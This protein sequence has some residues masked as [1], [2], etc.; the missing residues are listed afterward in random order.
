MSFILLRYDFVL[1]TR[2]YF[3]YPILLTNDLHRYC[4]VP[5]LCDDSHHQLLWAKPHLLANDQMKI[6]LQRIKKDGYHLKQ[7]GVMLNNF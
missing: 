5:K 4:L 3:F 2:E 1:Q 6:Q 7:A